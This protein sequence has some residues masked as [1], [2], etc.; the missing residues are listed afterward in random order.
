MQTLRLLESYQRRQTKTATDVGTSRNDSRRVSH[1]SSQQNCKAV[2]TD[3]RM[4]Q[5]DAFAPKRRYA[6]PTIPA[7]SCPIPRCHASSIETNLEASRSGQHGITLEMKRKAAF[8]SDQPLPLARI[9]VTN[10]PEIAGSVA[11]AQVEL[12]RKS[13]APRRMHHNTDVLSE[14]DFTVQ[15]FSQ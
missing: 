5:D 13:G 3:R 9:L 14:R 10:R 11:V 15:L 1:S 8:G 2:R 6:Y 12:E 4:E 7:D